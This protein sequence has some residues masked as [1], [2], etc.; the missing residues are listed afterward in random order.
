M[1]RLYIYAMKRYI[2]KFLKIT[3]IT[4]IVILVLLFLIPILFP[5]TVVEKTKAWA[6][7]SING[8]L[9][10][11]K[12]RLSFFNH[13]PSLTVTLYDVMLKGSEPYKKD[14]LVSSGE[15]ALGI[16]LK[17]LLFN[18]RIDIDK[19]FVTDALMNVKINEKGEANYNVYVPEKKQSAKTDS[20]N[21]S[22]RLEKINI[23][24]THFIYDD[25]SI[26]LYIDAKGFNYSGNGNL[27]EDIFDLYS[28]ARI[29]SV[30][31]YYDNEP[32]LLHKKV[33]ADLV[34]KINTNSLSFFF[35]KNKLMINRLPVHFDGKL[36]FMQNGYD[37]DLNLNSSNSELYDLITA[38]PPQYTTWLEKTKVTGNADVL[39]SIKGQYIASQHRSPDLAFDLK[40]RDGYVKYDGAPFPASNIFL[41]LHTRMPSLN[42]DSLQLKMDSLF[43]NVDKDYLSSN[44]QATG[45]NKPLVDGRLNAEM[46]LAKANRAF[47]LQGM[48]IAGLLKMNVTSKGRYDPA[49]KTLPVMRGDVLWQNGSVQTKYYPH[50]ISNIQLDAHVKDD[51]GTLKDLHV[52]I[53][54]FSFVFEGKPFHIQAALDN[55]DN[56]KYDI[57]AKGEIDVAKVYQVFS[58]KGL[59]LKGFIKA[60][61]ELQGSQTDAMQGHYDNLHNSGTLE[62]RDIKT[63]SD[64]FPHPFI[65]RQ[66]VFKFNQDKLS[67]DDFTGT[68]AHSDFKMNGYL[69][70]VI[71]YALSSSGILSGN[72]SMKSDYINAD[73]FIMPASPDSKK[74]TATGVIIIPPAYQLGLT[75]NVSKVTFNGLKLDSVHGQILVDKGILTLK[76]TGFNLIGCN[77]LMNATYG[78][79]SPTK[80]FFDYGIRAKDFDIARAYKEISLFHDLATAA[81]NAEGIVSLDYKLKGVLE[82][83]MHPAYPSLEGGGTLSV[84]DVKV[85]GLKLFAA[86]SKTTSRDSI[87]DPTLR[88]VD[89]KTTIKNNIITIERFKFKVFGFRPRIEGQTSFDGQLNLKIR[90]GLPPLGIIGIPLNVSGTQDNPKVGLGRGKKNGLQEKEYQQQD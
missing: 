27:S 38:L 69:Q 37:I 3:G 66:G 84:K 80:A 21:T 78:S 18:K 19:I 61:V 74:D 22:L 28:H 55:F 88:K 59:D 50:P 62:L 24:N 10:F 63:T 45:I 46:D 87:N 35:R 60:D 67:F 7:K 2:L 82:G 4:I 15:I 70:N 42:P 11:S 89:I 86:I 64:Y 65:I 77:V 71:D 72:F 14:T 26:P 16:N 31:F 33:N 75:A 30:D 68:Y 23:D 51:Q 53:R 81:A 8:E 40:I 90:L 32:Y 83:S 44:I 49:N 9:N 43:F 48:N 34:T 5:G 25:K 52:A 76:E 54:P 79:N 13:F 6:N 20:S 39:F 12:V 1:A 57:K 29:D 58:Q 73:E 47:G 56:I 85:K 17:S 36:D 41:D